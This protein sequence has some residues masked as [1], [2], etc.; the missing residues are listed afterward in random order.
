MPTLTGAFVYYAATPQVAN[1]SVAACGVA[2]GGSDCY[3]PVTFAATGMMI[4]G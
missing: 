3:C 2:H 4:F 1:R